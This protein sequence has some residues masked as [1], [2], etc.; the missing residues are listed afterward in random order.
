[1][2]HRGLH[3]RAMDPPM[4]PWV[5]CCWC[6]SFVK[7]RRK[8]RYSCTLVPLKFEIYG[9]TI[10][11]E[12][13][14]TFH[15]SRSVSPSYL[16]ILTPQFNSKL[17]VINDYIVISEDCLRYI[18]IHKFPLW[19]LEKPW[20]NR[21]YMN[22][23]VQLVVADKS[24]INGWSIIY[25]YFRLRPIWKAWC[26]FFLCFILCTD[27]YVWLNLSWLQVVVLLCL[28]CVILCVICIIAK[29][30]PVVLH[31]CLYITYSR[32]KHQFHMQNFCWYQCERCKALI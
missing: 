21:L 32:L 31:D 1:M 6:F 17:I 3:L 16:R 15:V 5:F 7:A 13:W 28:R 27:A 12:K 24:Q 8:S 30:Y 9:R 10:K 19:A 29:K 4:G 2:P 11:L 20:T 23:K 14:V 25:L 26:S 18:K 22:T